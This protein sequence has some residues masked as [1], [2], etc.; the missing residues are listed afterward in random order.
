MQL[1]SWLKNYVKKQISG[2]YCEQ[3]P[4][5]AGRRAARLLA[6]QGLYMFEAREECTIEQVVQF[7]WLHEEE[8]EKYPE[9]TI[10]FARLLIAG[11]V[12]HLSFIDNTIKEFLIRWDISRLARV[13]LSILRLSMYSLFFQKDIPPNVTIHEA[14]Q[15]SQQLSGSRSFSF[16]NGILDT[17]VRQK[18][19]EK[20]N[21]SAE[22]QK[23][24]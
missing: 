8:R 10:T 3:I 17:C 7:P 18:I 15:I 24:Y 2:F 11:T 4:M 9:D 1:M 16:I 6:V 14:V 22:K 19:R 23:R 12:E 20:R 21:D 5:N 13:D